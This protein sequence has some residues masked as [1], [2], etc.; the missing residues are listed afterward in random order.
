MEIPKRD[1][2]DWVKERIEECG[3]SQPTR[4]ADS[5]YWRNLYYTGQ[6]DPDVPC[7]HN[8]CFTQIDTVASFLFSPADV[9]FSVEFDGDDLTH[10]SNK[11]DITSRYVNRQFAKSGGHLAF[12]QAVDIALQEG[13]CFLKLTWSH[14]G[15]RPHVIRQQF[16]GMLREDENLLDEQDAFTQSYYLTEAAFKRLLVSHPDKNE[17]VAKASL[18]LTG[19]G[20][21]LADDYFH[22][23]IAGGSIPLA[24][25]PS[26]GFSNRVQVSRSAPGPTLAPDVAASLIKVTDLWVFDDERGDWTTIRY[27]EPD[28][29]IEGKYRHRNLSDIPKQHPF[30]KVCPNEVHGYAWGQSELSQVADLQGEYNATRQDFRNLLKLNVRPPRSYIGTS[31]VTAERVKALLTPGGTLTEADTQGKVETYAPTIPSELMPYLALIS[32]NFQEAGGLTNI[33]SGQ[34]EQGVRSGGHAGNLQR[35]ATARLRDRALATETSC[36]AFGGLYLDMAQAKNANA[37]TVPGGEE[38]KEET[39]LLSQLP[40]DASVVVDSHSSSPIF[41]GDHVNMAFALA[42]AGAMDQEDLIEQVQP[43]HA[44]KLIIKAKKRKAEAAAEKARIFKEAQKDPKLME[45]LVASATHHGR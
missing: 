5:A 30:I 27:A 2:I 11:A 24:A 18:T 33:L 43:P 38:G 26:Q 12:S 31:T 32:D 1:K 15:F 16:M 23:I 39:F 3:V 36:A 7:R 4:R 22:Q 29:L 10:W 14:H 44:D 45:K 25:S 37:F 13:C 34:G 6:V 40:S 20:D 19:A 42:K 28:L 9:R 35:N 41:S 8:K 21:A 17:L